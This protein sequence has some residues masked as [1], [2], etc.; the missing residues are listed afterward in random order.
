M[1]TKNI[2][3]ALTGFAIFAVISFFFYQ[4][5]YLYH[6]AY[7]EQTQLFLM[8]GEY[9]NT[10]FHRSAWLA[11]LAGDFLTQFYCFNYTGA[12]IITL[13][14][15]SLGGLFY[16][17]LGKVKFN[18]LCQK[19]QCIVL[20]FWVKMLLVI[21]LMI[22]EMF[23]NFG[24]DYELS[25]TLSMIGGISLFLLCTYLPQKWHWIL[26]ILLLPICYWL[27]GYGVF[28]FLLFCVIF[29]INSHRYFL[30]LLLIVISIV[31]PG[32]L[33]Q[34][35]HFTWKQAYQYPSNS[36]FSKPN[37]IIEDLLE[38][39]VL[40]F[41]G[42]WAKVAELSEKKNLQLAAS[43]YFYNLSHA[44]QGRLP[45]KL[46]DAYQPGTL[47]LLITLEPKTPFLSI[48]SSNE[49][50]FQMGDMTMAE[51]ATILGMIFSPKHR[52]SRTTKRLAEISMIN[53]D[54]LASFKYLRLLQKTIVY[55]GWANERLP[56]HETDQVKKWLAQKQ[57]FISK[58]DTLR[59]AGN[60]TLSLRAL[61]N[62]SP[63]NNMALDYLLCHDLLAKDI[64]SFM[65]DYI[66]Y[67]GIGKEMPNRLYSEALLI[68]LTNR[69][70]S[71]E[72]VK[73]YLIQADVVNDFND[74]NLQFEKDSGSGN[75][76]QV[77]YGKTYW[78]YYHFA[79][80][81]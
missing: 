41:Y 25:S 69:H 59:S 18:F 12:L 16:V 23:R 40:S 28:L 21:V 45:I 30:A 64:D 20:P 38:L 67:K 44:M 19:Q 17:A 42:S 49:A 53:N 35:Y 36:Y 29:E 2:Y 24:L 70:A 63:E 10:Y 8:S 74:Y 81:K 37:F 32:L 9:I 22:W 72:D 3:F 54:T 31:T 33:R 7:R 26:T 50:W 39:D 56:G 77:N 55:K 79:T 73:K 78:F 6:L 75:N 60:R 1:K 62:N 5:F 4:S 65:A 43:T 80:F 57:S 46:M 68:G 13:S 11:C 61:V 76:L 14:L 48:W 52:S 27:F 71:I 34:Q 51:H 15:I 47:G 58:Q 66:K